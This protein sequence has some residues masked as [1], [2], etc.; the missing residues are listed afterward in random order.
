MITGEVEVNE[1]VNERIGALLP[2]HHLYLWEEEYDYSKDDVIHISM[3][4]GYIVNAL[5]LTQTLDGVWQRDGEIV[6]ADF[7]LIEGS[8]VDGLYIK[9][10]YLRELLVDDFSMV[11][12]G[13]GEKQHTYGIPGGG[14]QSWSELSSLIFEDDSGKLIEI[15]HY[16]VENE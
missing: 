5:K 10:K 15:S 14:K 2:C 11:W 12:I 1:S 9:E 6:C 4:N 7:R 8:N 13:L 16:A 3:P